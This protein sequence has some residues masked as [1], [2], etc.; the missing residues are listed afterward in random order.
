[1]KHWCIIV[2][3][4]MVASIATAGVHTYTNQSVLSQGK[5]VKVSVKETGVHRISYETLKEW[6]LQPENI[7]VLGYG[8]AM[9]N[10]NF[11][12]HHWDDLPS[13]AFYMNKG[14]D[15]VFNAG[16][17]ILFYAQGPTSWSVNDEG[18][19]FHTQ[20][21]YSD[22]GYYFLTDQ[23]H[24]QK[25]IV[26]D[27]SSYN[28]NSMIDVDWYT[29]LC[30]HEKD[31][32]NLIDL[33]GQSGGG[34]EFYGEFLNT[35]NR[36]KSI[37]FPLNNVRTDLPAICIVDLAAYSGDVTP[38][39]V[40]YSG[41]A[42][43]ARMPAIS[44]SDY[45]TKAT[46]GSVKI[47]T[48]PT[49]S[50]KQTVRVQFKGTQSGATAYLN[51]VTM[52]VPCD[53]TMVGSQMP[54]TNTQYRNQFSS[55]RFHMQGANV[56]TQIW[57]VTDGVNVECMNTTFEDG[58]LS[59]IGPNLQAERYVAVNV[60]ATSWYEPVK[61]GQVNNQDLHALENIDYVIITPEAFKEPAMRL[62]Q[63]HEE[64]DHITWAVVT[65]EQVYNEF[66]S[67]TPDAT[68][69]RWLMKM[70]YD[71]AKGNLVQEPKN[72]L[73]MG[74]G[75]YDNRKRFS[76]SGV[77]Q[78]LTF[79]AKNSTSETMAYATDDYFGFLADNAGMYQGE[80]T[81]F[82][83]QM[84]IGVGRLPVKTIDEANEV[85][86]K[87]C[88]YMDDKVLGK[89][90]SQILFLADDGD[91][92]LHVQTADGGAERLRKKNKDFIVN[93]IYLDAYTQEISA[94]G[95]SYPLAKNQYDNLMSGGVLFMDYSGHGGYNNITNEL[96]MK[97]ADIQKMN[98]AN[99]GFWFLATCSFSHFDGGI[100]SAGELAVLNPNGGAIGVLS[101]CR[102]V[103]ATQNTVLNRNLCDT[104][105]GHE[106]PFNYNMTLGEATR[107]AKNKTGYDANKM[108]YVLLGDPAIKL[109]YPTD[110]QV[111]TLVDIDTIHAL[112]IQS[113]KGYVQTPSLDTATWF[114]GKLDVTI[115]DK[116]QQITTR[117]NDETIEEDKTKITYNDYPNILFSGQ[118]DVVEGKF[119]FSFMVPKDIR[120]NYGNGRIVYYA[121][122]LETREEA[123]GHFED[124]VIGGSNSLIVKDTTGPEL[125]IYLNT[126]AFQSGDET[127]EFPHFYAD[128]YD[129]NGI[130]T[131]GTGIGHDLLMVVDSDPRQTYILNNYFSASNNSYQS[132][133][134]SYKMAEQSEGAHT[135]T[136]RAWDMYNNSSTASLNFH[137]VKGI[138]PKIYSVT[139]YPNP[140]AST[141]VM[142][143]HIQYD[144]PDEIVETVVCLYDI[145]G[146]L[147]HMHTQKGTDGIMW[148]MNELATHP[149]VYL[150][151]V[152]IK[153]TT[154]NHVSKAGKI[155]VTK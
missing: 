100:T 152:K 20:N 88:T 54:I 97:S 46:K 129:E 90:K 25:L 30:V 154:S 128:I 6:G 36:L 134:V 116:M 123:I 117:D 11:L 3:M 124:F 51:Y 19:W 39:Q 14:T 47:I 22:Y 66:S 48:Q 8:G 103:Y 42:E 141:G 132:G 87:L 75:T 89:W 70:L 139:T 137:V 131:V 61:I 82:R 133:Q 115:F 32:L 143:V 136:F 58:T 130:N 138:D 2:L 4:C 38:V 86:D 111:K 149:G 44:V 10:E 73:L 92:G 93:K 77:R 81:E 52:Q 35:Q 7:A 96:F 95:E 106:T 63:K 85:V 57:R 121:H 113:I 33:K 69:Y 41:K 144:Q 76:T 21:P 40:T 56:N 72:L 153:T 59:W 112:S 148:N 12:Q 18:E 119:E 79:Q 108:A 53:L 91:H 120:Y 98:N 102:T 5:F 67:G 13:V 45:H 147:M 23:L 151:Q 24:L 16:D 64:V 118:T 80:F 60:N 109:N 50:A 65:D 104:L 15:N 27:Q 74:D 34:R 1:M 43:S 146:Q 55:M 127:Y 150:Y 37:T 155:I 62:A 31:S 71:R 125:H 9:L 122:D 28:T 105:F 145:S 84:N 78:L 101:A 68:A 26:K 110:L 94:A 114:N 49:S 83:A 142:N 99:Q 135:L 126:P 29:A 140:V 17:Y 107:I